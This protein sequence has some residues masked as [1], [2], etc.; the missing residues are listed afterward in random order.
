MAKRISLK[1][2]LLALDKT[3]FVDNVYTKDGKEVKEKNVLVD[4]VLSEEPKVITSGETWELQNIGFVTE[5]QTKEERT[6]KAP[7]RPIVGSATTFKDK[8]A[9]PSFNRDSQGNEI[10]GYDNSTTVADDAT[11]EDIIGF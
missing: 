6:A 5:T 2:N 1:I 8:V 11:N 9:V 4:I 10:K 3:R 7:F